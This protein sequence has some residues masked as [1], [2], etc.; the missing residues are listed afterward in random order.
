MEGNISTLY[1]RATDDALSSF[2]KNQECHIGTTTG[3]QEEQHP[4]PIIY[5]GTGCLSCRKDDDHA[6]LLLCEACNDEYHTYC[7]DPPLNS[8]PEADFFCDKCKPLHDHNSKDGLDAMVAALSPSF[9]SRYG[10]IVWAGGGVGFGW[11]P[12][13]GE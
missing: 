10:E 4:H 3:R 6:N 13:C 2:I 1:L 5:E 11:W 8:V 9:T 7:L 12:A